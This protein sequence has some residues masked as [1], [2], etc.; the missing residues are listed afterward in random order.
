MTNVL[1]TSVGRRNYLVDYF[2][3]ALGDNGKVF[4]ANSSRYSSALAVADG[5]FI[6]P[7]VIEPNYIDEIINICV[8]N[9][10]QL[11]ISVFDYDLP[12]LA[13]ARERFTSIGTT[14]AL[15]DE[16]ILDTCLD[17][18]Q[19]KN[20]FENLYIGYPKT[21][22]TIDA[23]ISE[24][25]E[26]SISLPLIVKP[27]WGTGSIGIFIAHSIDEL[28]VAYLWVKRQI[29]ESYV[30]DLGKRAN[31]VM[32]QEYLL[33]EEYGLD[34]I[35]DFHG[36]YVTTFVK[37]KIAMRSGETDV[38]VTTRDPVLEALGR[39]LGESLGHIGLLD[40]DVFKQNDKVVVLEMNP[41][42]GG[43]YP[44]SHL[45]GANIPAAYIAWAKEEV[46]NKDWFTIDEN[47][48]CAK[49]VSVHK[50]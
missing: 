17:K 9:Q 35:N 49:G 16:N 31:D 5:A 14:L 4:A 27:R 25:S 50:I 40:V 1:I 36:N 24:L 13:N 43:G 34:V 45:A 2:R 15:S 33:G 7:P 12:M 46:V 10:V 20:F 44:F 3:D 37:R 8:S 41:R 47:V 23:V 48:T 26:K 30:G 38:A 18:F 32:I 6:V 11:L 21:Y 22:L 19:T 42:F 39:K 28:R 29:S